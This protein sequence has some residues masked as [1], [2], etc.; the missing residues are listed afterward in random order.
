MATG[1]WFWR[2][3]I[4][5]HRAVLRFPARPG[6]RDGCLVGALSA[7]SRRANVPAMF[8]HTRTPSMRRASVALL[9]AAGLA[10][11]GCATAEDDPAAPGE[12][13]D[14]EV[15]DDTAED[16]TEDT[17]EDDTMEDDTME[18]DTETEE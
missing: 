6:H 13:V 2:A 8:T 15:E 4:A 11:G 16:T 10:L 9:A 5:T 18:E 17:T 14:V 12:D 3:G 7:C 1:Q